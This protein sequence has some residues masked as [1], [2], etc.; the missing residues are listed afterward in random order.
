MVQ[1]DNPRHGS[2]RVSMRD[3]AR[4]AGVSPATVSAFL[5]GKR[6]VSLATRARLEAAIN[7]HGYRAN[8]SARA[9]RERL[10]LP[11]PRAQAIAIP[12]LLHA[13]SGFC[14]GE[15]ELEPDGFALVEAAYAVG[16]T[17]F[18]GH[19]AKLWSG[20]VLSAGGDDHYCPNERDAHANL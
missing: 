11:R 18:H 15:V 4:Q 10:P 19:V 6:P 1:A 5:S 12:C 16:A 2:P 17:E 8:A 14:G 20:D 9:S 13:V 7:M 3:I